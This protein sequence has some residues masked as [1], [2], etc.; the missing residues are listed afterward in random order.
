MLIERPGE[1][2]QEGIA[3]VA[4]ELRGWHQCAPLGELVEKLV[5][6]LAGSPQLDDICV[7]AVRRADHQCGLSERL[8]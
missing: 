8:N 3:R 4:E 2:L 5:A 6:T 1:D 7:L